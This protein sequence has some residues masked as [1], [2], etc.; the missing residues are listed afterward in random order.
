VLPQR[1][2]FTF[3]GARGSGRW[4]QLFNFRLNVSTALKAEGWKVKN[5]PTPA[6]GGGLI[7]IGYP[8]SDHGLQ[9]IHSGTSRVSVRAIRLFFPG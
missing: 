5:H 7:V 6:I 3:H 4:V 9:A 2:S 8:D 1:N